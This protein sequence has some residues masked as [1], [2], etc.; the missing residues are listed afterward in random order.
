MNRQK[1]IVIISAEL[2]QKSGSENSNRTDR[3]RGLLNRDHYSNGNFAGYTPAKRFHNEKFEDCFIVALKDGKQEGE[4]NR[5]KNIAEDFG[6]EAIIHSDSNRHTELLFGDGT[7]S[8][9]K[10]IGVP[11]IEAESLGSYITR[12][13]KKNG[14][15]TNS[16]YYIT[17]K[18]Q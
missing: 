13:V 10:L 17:R 9:G 2:P 12:D 14:I 3:L 11:Q 8:L 1:H 7:E 18:V 5:L 16:Y 15:V 4:L 6:Q